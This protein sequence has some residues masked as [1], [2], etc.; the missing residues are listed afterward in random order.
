MP[1]GTDSHAKFPHSTLL[2]SADADHKDAI[3]LTLTE[4][5]LKNVL[6]I[7]LRRDHVGMTASAQN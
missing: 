3:K 5:F 2:L 4:Q 1:K 7:P 6:T